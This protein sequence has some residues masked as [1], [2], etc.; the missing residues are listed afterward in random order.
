MCWIPRKEDFLLRAHS[1]FREHSLGKSYVSEDPCHAHHSYDRWCCQCYA[2]VSRLLY[3]L[4]AGGIHLNPK[5]SYTPN[6]S[7][8]SCIDS[9]RSRSEQDYWL[10]L[11]P[12]EK[13]QFS[14]AGR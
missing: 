1:H 6:K 8:V 2:F 10:G 7:L 11:D 14:L 4:S 12:D 13:A 5:P 9:I 3:E